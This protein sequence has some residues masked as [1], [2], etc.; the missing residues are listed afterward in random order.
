[1]P[2]T[3]N[4]AKQEAWDENFKRSLQEFAWETVTKYP[5]SMVT[6]AKEK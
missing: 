6:A 1:M 2:T 5:Y 3:V 4:S